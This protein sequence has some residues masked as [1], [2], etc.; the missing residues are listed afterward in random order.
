[1]QA[2]AVSGVSVLVPPGEGGI[3]PFVPGHFR[4]GGHWQGGPGVPARD[5]MVPGLWRWV[6]PPPLSLLSLLSNSQV[7][8]T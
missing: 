5:S 8:H 7:S 4:L 1:M 2:R 6:Q 3:A